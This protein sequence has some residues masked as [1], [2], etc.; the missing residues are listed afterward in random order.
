MNPQLKQII[1]CYACAYLQASDVHQSVLSLVNICTYLSI[2]LLTTCGGHTLDDS[3]LHRR[4][5]TDKHPCIY[6]CFLTVGQS[7]STWRESLEIWREHAKSPQK[8]PLPQWIQ[9]GNLLV[10]HCLTQN[11]SRN[12]TFQIVKMAALIPIPPILGRTQYLRSM[13]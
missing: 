10:N 2:H 6:A 11:K 4:V 8:G 13:R 1:P 7:V 9:T 5:N 12:I 3:W